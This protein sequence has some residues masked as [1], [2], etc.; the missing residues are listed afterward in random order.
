VSALIATSE[1][2]EFDQRTV[3][4][5]LIEEATLILRWLASDGVRLVPGRQ[6]VSWSMPAYGASG[7]LARISQARREVVVALPVIDR[8][9]RPAG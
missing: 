1:H 5:G 3:P 4:A 6:P 8:N 2:V 7:L 9:L